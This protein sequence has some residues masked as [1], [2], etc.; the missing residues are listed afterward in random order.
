MAVNIKF[1]PSSGSQNQTVT[2][3]GGCNPGIDETIQFQVQTEDGSKTEII[4]VTQ[5]G[6]REVLMVSDG[7]GGYTEFMPSDGGTFNVVKEEWKE[8]PDCGPANGVYVYTSDG[9]LVKPEE[10]DVANNDQ[11]AGVAVIDTNCR[12]AISK[13][14]PMVN[15]IRWS[16]A[17][18][19]TDVE[20]ILTTSSSD[21]A[22]TDYA[23][24]SNTNLIRTQASGENSSNNAA[25][26]CYEQTL[27][28][29]HGYLPAAGELYTLWENK[30]EVN[31]ALTTIGATTIDTAF[32]NLYS[33]NYHYPWSSTEYSAGRA[34]YLT[35][36]R[37]SSPLGDDAKY[38]VVSL[39]YAFPVF[40]LIET[41]GGQ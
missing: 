3:S 39:G 10:W 5:E 15:N 19:G 27:N 14:L 36:E 30:T 1:D 31:N 37:S 23:G 13:S 22:Q 40:P 21:T 9:Q 6:K 18:R 8:N 33:S 35:W 17:L 34:W 32:N 25:H 26:Y 28:E 38:Y 12:F 4:N 11:A 20:G 29:Q 2:V 41:G 7:Q 16:N 24:Q